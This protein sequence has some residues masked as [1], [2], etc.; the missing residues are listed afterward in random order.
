MSMRGECASSVDY[1]GAV[2]NADY[3]EIDFL[4]PQDE[5]ASVINLYTRQMLIWGV[6]SFL[7][8]GVC[9]G[10]GLEAGE[11]ES[12]KHWR[13]IQGD[14]VDACESEFCGLQE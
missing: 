9:Y 6:D 7:R 2:P 11:E 13:F 4:N 10:I 1:Y 8:W 3:V 5:K 14:G 12:C